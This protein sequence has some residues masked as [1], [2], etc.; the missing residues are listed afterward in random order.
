MGKMLKRKAN[1]NWDLLNELFVLCDAFMYR[2]DKVEIL[3]F[4]FEKY[5]CKSS[6]AA[7]KSRKRR[8]EAITVCETDIISDR[9]INEFITYILNE[10]ENTQL[11]SGTISTFI[12]DHGSPPLIKRLKSFTKAKVVLPNLLK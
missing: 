6:A 11:V 4:L 3:N 2:N 12:E 1:G 10:A 7:Y 9:F 5:S 8:Y